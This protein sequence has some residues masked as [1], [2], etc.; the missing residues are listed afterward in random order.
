[1]TNLCRQG[2][3]KGM[4]LLGIKSKLEDW[5]TKWS[6]CPQGRAGK[7]KWLTRTCLPWDWR[8]LLEASHLLGIS[9]MDTWCQSFILVLSWLLVEKKARV[10]CRHL[11]FGEVCHKTSFMCFLTDCLM[12][13][14]HCTI[15]RL[16]HK[17]VVQTDVACL[18]Y[19]SWH[20]NVWVE[21]IAI[22]RN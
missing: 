6:T 11:L 22:I 9:G 16:H 10:I 5:S 3:K 2:N 12:L 13:Q 18:F 1:M 21:L 17:A 4:S 15:S 8:P 19:C 14:Q 7:S 20:S